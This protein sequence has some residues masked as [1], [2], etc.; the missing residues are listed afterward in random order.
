MSSGRLIGA[1]RK[2][3]NP[4]D[5]LRRS[6]GSLD[7]S[8]VVRRSV[9]CGSVGSNV[10]HVIQE[11]VSRSVPYRD[12]ANLGRAGDRTGAGDDTRDGQRSRG[13]GRQ[14]KCGQLVCFPFRL[15]GFLDVSDPLPALTGL[16]ILTIPGFVFLSVPLPARHLQF[17]FRGRGLFARQE[18]IRGGLEVRLDIPL[19][20]ANRADR[21]VGAVEILQALRARIPQSDLMVVGG[22]EPPKDTS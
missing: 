2:R 4:P 22:S 7:R 18:M 3:R 6:D 17:R 8:R 19:V 12:V 14:G 15:G 9:S 13:D 1:R 10:V 16:R 5:Q 20:P 11:V 21:K